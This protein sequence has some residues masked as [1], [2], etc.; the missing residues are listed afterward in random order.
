MIMNIFVLDRDPIQAAK[1]HN[2]IHLRKMIVEY[3]QLLSTAH[4]VLD[5]DAKADALGMYKTTH[6]NH[7]C[8]IWL[9][10]SSGNYMFLYSLFLACIEEYSYRFGKD[11]ATKKLVYALNSVPL[12]YKRTEI[13]AFVT[14]VAEDCK[15]SDA[16]SSYREYYRKHKRVYLSRGKEKRMDIWTNRDRPEWFD[17]E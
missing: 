3:A 11:H 17:H 13:T 15:V 4:R 1:Y 14:A 8:G 10:E 5:G 2:D 6:K 7:P 12:S 16:I 9:R